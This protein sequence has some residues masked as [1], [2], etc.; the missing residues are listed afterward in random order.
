[1]QKT[2]PDKTDGLVGR[3]MRSASSERGRGMACPHPREQVKQLEMRKEKGAKI[4]KSCK[5]RGASSPA[6]KGTRDFVYLEQ[7]RAEGVISF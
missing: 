5:R 7:S 1:M 2:A 4:L 6:E 3:A